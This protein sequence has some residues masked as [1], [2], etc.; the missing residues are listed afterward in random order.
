MENL[1][2]IPFRRKSQQNINQAYVKLF[3]LDMSEFDD[4][5]NYKRSMLFLRVSS[6]SIV[7][8]INLKMF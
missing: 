1:P 6:R 8:L 3:K 2:P 5:K 4:P 7:R